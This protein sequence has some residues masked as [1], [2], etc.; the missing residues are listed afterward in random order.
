MEHVE[1]SRVHLCW[2]TRERHTAGHHWRLP[3]RVDSTRLNAPDGR[4]G[5]LAGGGTCRRPRGAATKQRV[6]VTLRSACTMSAG[7]PGHSER[8]RAGGWSPTTAPGRGRCS[9]PSWSAARPP[10]RRRAGP[11]VRD[12]RGDPGCAAV[13]HSACGGSMS[14]RHRERCSDAQVKWCA[15]CPRWG[16]NPHWADFKDA[17]LRPLWPLPATMP[18]PAPPP[19]PPADH[20]RRHFMPRTMPRQLPAPSGLIR[21][22]SPRRPHAAS[23]QPCT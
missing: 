21:F 5:V 7:R 3:G 10:R 17:A 18:T 19:A 9:R 15:G 2:C 1:S 16:S 23:A 12:D 20:S 14:R 8:R 11:A 6:R 22:P 13:R 4:G